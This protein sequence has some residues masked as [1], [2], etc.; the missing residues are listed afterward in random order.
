M[1]LDTFYHSQI[2]PKIKNLDIFNFC[3]NI[4][5]ALHWTQEVFGSY[6]PICLRVTPQQ[7]PKL[8]DSLEIWHKSFI[9][10][11][12][13][14]TQFLDYIAKIAGVKECTKLSQYSTAY[15]RKC[16]CIFPVRMWLDKDDRNFKLCLKFV[17]NVYVLFEISCIA[18]GVH[19][20]NSL[21]Q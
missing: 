1:Q 20:I 19:C 4:S 8:S 15:G 13:L 12:K 9:C 16:V 7:S 3:R 14:A 5:E 2:F 18:F 11:A 17:T 10:L 6:I 21:I